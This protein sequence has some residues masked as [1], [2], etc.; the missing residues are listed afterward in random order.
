MTSPD[1]PRGRLSGWSRIRLRQI[2]LGGGHRLIE[3][4]AGEVFFKGEIM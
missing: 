3:A 2:H 1:D 4:T